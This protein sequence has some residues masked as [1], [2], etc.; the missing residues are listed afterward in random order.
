MGPLLT[1]YIAGGKGLATS[2]SSFVQYK[3]HTGGTAFRLKPITLKGV[4]EA[5]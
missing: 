3:A 1:R 5:H 4:G 2:F